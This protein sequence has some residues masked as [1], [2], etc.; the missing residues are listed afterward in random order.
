MLMKGK[1]DIEHDG[2]D[3]AAALA[4]QM[5][6]MR[7]KMDCLARDN[8][9]L[10]RELDALARESQATISSLRSQLEGRQAEIERLLEQIRLANRRF[11]GS[12][13]EKAS[14]EQ[15]SLFNDVESAADGS[16]AEPSLE[17]V[18]DNKAPKNR[19][20]GGKRKIDL[21]RFETVVVEHELPAEE[22]A[23]RRCGSELEEVGVE[24]TK[25]LRLVPAHFVVEEHRTHKYRCRP[26]CEANAEG[27]ETASVLVRAH[28]PKNGLPGSIA[29]PSLIS[30]IV[31]A[32][33]VNSMPL[34]RIE[35]DFASLGAAIS[36]QNMANWVIHAYERWLAKVHGRI[37]AELL[38]HKV[39][40]ADETEVQVLKEPGRDARSVSR[41]WLFCSAE[42]DTPAYAYEYRD[43]RSKA[44][45]EDFLRGWSGTLV[46]D[47]YDAYYSL[48]NGGSIRNVACLVH[49]RRKFIEVIDSAGGAE[50]ARRA[51]SVALEA[52]D[53]INAMFH[54]DNS[55][56]DVG[57]DE[58]R[59]LRD[60]KLRPLMEDF[61]RWLDAQIP[62]AAPRLKLHGALCYAKKYWP[63]VMNALDDGGAAL[64]N[65]VAERGI[66]PFVIG[67]KNWL[68]SDTPRGARASCGMYSIVTTAR[69]NGVS[70]RPYIEWLLTELP[71]A[72]ELTDDVLDSF[73]PWSDRV[74]RS[75]RL[76]PEKARRLAEIAEEPI[77]DIDPDTIPKDR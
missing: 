63:Y 4:A 20:R 12:K 57:A 77:M 40:H 50:K 65:N 39:I 1:Q 52:R 61:G 21:A 2:A 29:T 28:A 48:A 30:H 17:D 7:A 38:G 60:E 18:A 14:P 34:Y 23:C 37:R 45:A 35:G 26:C 68:F 70:P 31:N 49:V 22:R 56:G 15:L 72:G 55:F 46:T 64:S 67:R 24:V 16:A 27:G 73:M 42:A 8:E 74:P 13:S 43:T 9:A 66:K 54:M 41:C 59:A 75:F 58:R 3:S 44:V 36:R 5:S 6:E 47:G 19:R 51:R 71:N 53:K 10:S 11:F 32:K 76:A 69:M 62:K 25:R 33:Y